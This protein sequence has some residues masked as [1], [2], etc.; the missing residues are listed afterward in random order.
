MQS[1]QFFEHFTV[2]LMS[3]IAKKIRFV[4]SVCKQ[5]NVAVEVLNR[6]NRYFLRIA[7]RGAEEWIGN[8]AMHDRRNI[9]FSSLRK[10]QRRLEV[11]QKIQTGRRYFPRIAAGPLFTSKRVTLLRAVPVCLGPRD[12]G[13]RDKRRVQKGRAT[14][15]QFR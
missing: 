11:T 5:T 14:F 3:R 6:S 15:P 2:F 9:W 4:R 7:E 13:S 10:R 8:R 1:E 12:T